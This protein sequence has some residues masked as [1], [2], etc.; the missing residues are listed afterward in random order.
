MS[1]LA[2]LRD[3]FHS[4]PPG[5]VLWERLCAL[6]ASADDDVAA[7]CD[8]SLQHMRGWPEAVPRQAPY[9]W[10]DGVLCG[11]TVPWL[12]LADTVKLDGWGMTDERLMLLLGKL[13]LGRLRCL[14]MERNALTDRGAVAL[15]EA[16]LLQGAQ[17]CR[18]ALLGNAVGPVGARALR[19]AFGAG[20]CPAAEHHVLAIGG[21]TQGELYPLEGPL[22]T[23]G[24]HSSCT[25]TIPDITVSRR[26]CAVEVTD[27]FHLYVT[28]LGSSCG[29]F[30]N[31]RR[32]SSQRA[33]LYRGDVLMVGHT[34][35][36][37]LDGWEA[38]ARASF[39]EA[40]VD[41]EPGVSLLEGPLAW[42][43][44]LGLVA[45]VNGTGK[46][47]TLEIEDHVR[48]ALHFEDGLL[49]GARVDEGDPA[50]TTD[51]A[52]ALFKSCRDGWFRFVTREQP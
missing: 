7:I 14:S 25:L 22:T 46:T 11:H 4:Y 44:V 12:M 21:R 26:H 41:A 19:E 10:L 6:L 34:L 35:L 30:I 28:D 36:Q 48:G 47:T 1:T 49:V 33:P 42:I 37:L 16:A 2:A 39:C 45:F 15:A 9:R 3:L 52:L 8:Y 38:K 31:G 24:R 13:D 27:P 40:L 32:P 43:S 17:G 18:L 23:M 51:E 20:W 50:V 29:I 5:P